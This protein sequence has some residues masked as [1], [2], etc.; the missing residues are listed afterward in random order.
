[1][2]YTAFVAFGLVFFT[3]GQVARNL[4][5][6]QPRIPLIMNGTLLNLDSHGAWAKRKIVAA[7]EAEKRAED[8]PAAYARIPM[9]VSANLNPA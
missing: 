3:L 2:G 5:E 8:D 7:I 1:M 9:L 6:K 4:P